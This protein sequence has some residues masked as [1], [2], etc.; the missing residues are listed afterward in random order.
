MEVAHSWLNP[1]ELKVDPSAKGITYDGFDR[2]ERA[3]VLS[4]NGRYSKI[5]F[6]L[7]A[8]KANPAVNPVVIINNLTGSL[9]QL[10]L[11]GAPLENSDFRMGIES[12]IETSRL[13]VWINKT[14]TNPSRIM[15]Q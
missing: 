1:P 12:G 15:I 13:V 9:P 11:D 10:L 4:V 5:A 7:Q 6:N 8:D 14:L 3:Y 2:S